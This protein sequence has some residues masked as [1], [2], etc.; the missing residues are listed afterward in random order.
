MG[1]SPPKPPPVAAVAPG[2][3]G[4]AP[5]PAR[6]SAAGAQGER[7]LRVAAATGECQPGGGRRSH[8]FSLN[9]MASVHYYTV[10]IF[11]WTAKLKTDFCQNCRYHKKPEAPGARRSPRCGGGP[12]PGAWGCPGVGRDV[13]DL[14]GC[15]GPGGMWGS[16]EGGL[17]PFL[18]DGEPRTPFP[19]GI[20]GSRRS[21]EPRPG[22]AGLAPIPAAPG[23]AE[24]PPPPPGL[25]GSIAEE[26]KQG[27]LC[28]ESL[29]SSEPA[30]ACWHRPPAEAASP[31]CGTGGSSA[32]SPGPAPRAARP[33]GP[34]PGWAVCPPV[35][36]PIV[37]QPVAA[38]WG[39]C[40]PPSFTR[41]PTEPCP[42]SPH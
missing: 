35:S 37:S 39:L 24:P 26:L 6:R 34:W 40:F 2:A 23:A 19:C 12:A 36:V 3:P 11:I 13:G 5:V 31:E 33:G 32:R 42:L 30:S 16:G 22:R 21:P 28:L 1:V 7:Q 4:P 9:F 38:P 8:C 25:P 18:C 10:R 27:H 15:G 29:R 20:G 41:C 17:S 14:E